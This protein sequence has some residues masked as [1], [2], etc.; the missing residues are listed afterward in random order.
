MPGP[1]TLRDV[2]ALVRRARLVG[3]AHLA[4]ALDGAADLTP[5]AAIGRLVAAGLLTRFQAAELAAGRGAGLWLGAYKVLDP[6]KHED[7]VKDEKT[8][9]TQPTK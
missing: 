6:L 8:A 5:D 1:E 7:K 3:E 2:L 4:G 9:T